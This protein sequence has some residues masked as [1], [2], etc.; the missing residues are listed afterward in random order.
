MSPYIFRLRREQVVLHSEGARN[1]TIAFAA[2]EIGHFC[3]LQP[4]I[5]RICSFGHL[6]IQ[7]LD[8]LPTILSD[9]T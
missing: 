8:T 5:K 3:F 9:L 2:A 1:K 4:Q 6:F 7:A